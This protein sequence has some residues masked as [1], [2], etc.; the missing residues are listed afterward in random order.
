[1]KALAKSAVLIIPLVQ[2]DS[3]W[4]TGMAILV[5]LQNRHAD[6]GAAEIWG[7]RKRPPQATGMNTLV[8]SG[9]WCMSSDLEPMKCIW[10]QGDNLN[11]QTQGQGVGL[12]VA[13][14]CAWLQTESGTGLTQELRVPMY[15]SPWPYQQGKA[16]EKVFPFSWCRNRTTKTMISFLKCLIYQANSRHIRI[17][18]SDGN[19]AL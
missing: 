9:L 6:P 14:F 18:F 5:L 11:S 15:L 17:P 12:D 7:T 19:Y 13:Q 8:E 1:M 3:F 10:A 2:M 4:G 16:G